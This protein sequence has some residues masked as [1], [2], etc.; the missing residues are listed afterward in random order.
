MAL[1]SKTNLKL[2]DAICEGPIEGFVHHRKSIF[3][4]ETPLS[5]DQVNKETVYVKGTKGVREQDDAKQSTRFYNAQ[6]T[7]EEV[8]TQIGSNYTET[9]GQA[10]KVKED[11]RDYGSGQVIR[12]I[13]D[14]EVDFVKLIFTVNKL[15]C[16]A[17][18]G[19]ARGQL[20][21][22][23]IKLSVQIQDRDGNFDNIDIAPINTTQKN[24]IKG[25]ARSGY[26][27]ET[28]EIDL[29]RYKFPYRIRVRKLDFGDEI[30]LNF[31]SRRT[32]ELILTKGDDP[33]T[34]HST[35]RKEAKDRA[36]E[37]A[38]EIS[39]LD[40]EDLPRRTSLQDKRADSITW[41]SMVLG[42]RV[43]TSY[44]FTAI[45]YMSID[46][47]EYNT[48]PARAYEVKGKKVK[49]PSNAIVKND[50]SLLFPVDENGQDLIP[51]DGSL[52]TNLEYTTC[53]VCCFY[54][55]V[56]NSR[57]GAGDFINESN[58]NWIDLID[59]CK[60][61]NEEVDTPDGKEPRFAINTVLGSQAEA[62]NVL[63]DMASIF[64]GMLFWKADNV[65]IAADHGG[66][67]AEN[68]EAIHVFSNSNIVNGS[69]TYS[70]SSLKT[71]S[72]RVRVRYNDPGNFYKTNFIVIE[73]QQ[74]IEK[75]G[76]QEKSVVAF[77]CT[78]K[79]QAQRLGR[80]IMQSEKLHDE[81]ISFSVGLEGLNVL[82]GQVFEVS[83]EMRLATRLAGRVVGATT[84][85]VDLDQPA[86]PLPSGSNDKL[87][88][89]MADGTVETRAIASVSGIRVTLASPF[90]QPPPDDAL[91]AIKN[92][93]ISLTKYRCL[94]VAESEEGTYG[95]VGVKHVD[96]IYQIV[97]ETNTNLDLPAASE[98][99]LAPAA[100]QDLAISFQQI[101]D[102]RNTT[103][104][105]T[106]SWNRGLSGNAIEFQ[107]NYKIGDG[108]NLIE[109][110]T[111]DTSIDINGG[112][113]P[114]KTLFARV[115]A[116]GPEPSRKKSERKEISR[117]IGPA[118]T[119]DIA[120][121]QATVVLPP[122]P[123]EVSIQLLGA[124]QVIL[125]WSA[126]ASGQKLENFVAQIRHSA[127]TNGTGTWAGSTPL[128]EVEARTTSAVLPLLN[129]EYLVK[130][131]NDQ[132]QRSNGAGSAVINVPDAVPKYDYEVL[133]EDLHPGRFAGQKN[134]VVYSPEYDGLV[135]DGNASFDKKVS[136]LDEHGSDDPK[137]AS[138]LEAGKRY[139]IL[140]VGT[141][142]FTGIGA[143][144]N[145][146]G[147]IFVATGSGTGTGTVYGREIDTIFGAQFSDGE[148]IFQNIV[149]LGAKY[150]VRLLRK[151]EARGLYKSD[152]IDNRTVLIDLWSDFDGVIP[153]DTEVELYF[154][155]SNLAATGSVAVNSLVAG[156]GYKILTVGTTDFVA[157]GAGRNTVNTS[158]IATGAGTGTGL[159]YPEAEI[160]QEN[161]SKLQLEDGGSF[162]KESDVDFEEWIP[163]ANNN[164]VGRVFQFKAVLKTNHVDQTPLI[165]ELGVSVQLER[166]TENSG[167]IGSGLGAKTITFEKPFYIDGD[168]AVS[169]AITA[170]AMESGD[171][172]EMS[173][174]TSTGFTI[175]FKGTFDGDQFIDRFFSYTAV[176]YG[177]QQP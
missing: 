35:A 145:T 32:Q 139:K 126:T 95:I 123:E 119:S 59:I 84:D 121:G 65:Q 19:L 54:D 103:T 104:R 147:T 50:G 45:A 69:F 56:T 78:S 136:N 14:S 132:K 53:P 13:T 152:L 16:V 61:C 66:L 44:P 159:V 57:Y 27:F 160:V 114:G 131:V 110:V 112:L 162:D 111:T 144:A 77:G 49:I 76:V 20:F 142:N 166:R 124:D 51:Y 31:V 25:I 137:A 113:I 86:A 154:R 7:I 24:V 11:G 98:Y 173:E 122:D 100:P 96:G 133:R 52:K 105:A 71:R 33:D 30:D 39:Y 68:V 128:I 146:V 88:V 118:G 18:E 107:V 108:G 1:N 164:Y 58:L 40:L 141:T 48:L 175:T 149:D 90:T 97:E 92:D 156:T 60:Y 143:S 23:Q 158:F 135:F 115:R 64:H 29:T 63:Q 148:Y 109:V 75:Y 82:P 72:T 168:T 177:T 22:A 171:Y 55:M 140:S 10:D 106:I 6:T 161:N 42:K 94:S 26:Q 38:F 99:D 80:W 120:D 125:S 28:Q 9:L 83:D 8:N 79:Y 37:K 155:K 169:V 5:F 176:G 62:Y 138:S 34:A 89:V 130:F 47:E 127:I 41:Q 15:F 150:N 134:N 163:L 167:V 91:F 36:L 93:S 116:V 12:D 74:L 87:T 102:G 2:I 174:P 4:N 153:D 21:F 73:D 151:L 101:D 157:I 172:F 117:V 85:F 129:G 17:P 70:G 170:L 46:S 3:L 165:D 67:R 81:T 43:K